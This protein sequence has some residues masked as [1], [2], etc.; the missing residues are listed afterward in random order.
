MELVGI[1]NG[2][3]GLVESDF[4][5]LDPARVARI[6][7]RGGSILG[8]DNI[9][10]GDAADFADGVRRAG[11]D[12]VI[13]VGGNGSLTQAAEMAPLMRRGAVVGVPKTIDR[14]VAGTEATIGFDTAVEAVESACERLIDTAESHRRVMIVEVM[15]RDSGFIALH[16]ALAGGADVALL[17][18]IPYRVRGVVDA[19]V[20][21]EGRELTHTLIVAAEGAVAEGGE[22]ILDRRRT[23]TTGIVR[24]GGIGEALAEQ[25]RGLIDDEVRTVNLAPSAAGRPADSV[26]PGAGH[27]VR[28]GGG[29]GAAGRSQ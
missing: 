12:G 18:E 2:Y 28:G 24:L 1:R 22:P 13:V 14:D 3:R 9:F 20:E 26:R 27:A 29:A 21:R 16:G 7:R 15:G 25:L 17:P 5:R 10:R 11:L 4:L 19:I 8:C 6:H 23:E